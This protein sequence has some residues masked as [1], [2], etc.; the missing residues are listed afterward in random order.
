[1][2]QPPTQEQLEQG[3]RPSA[4]DVVFAKQVILNHL[5]DSPTRNTTVLIRSVLQA[6][7]APLLD[8]REAN[9]APL[10]EQVARCKWLAAARLALADL[11][12]AGLLLPLNSPGSAQRELSIAIKTTHYSHGERF[13]GYDLI[14]A[15]TYRLSG[16]ASNWDLTLLYDPDIYLSSLEAPAMHDRIR[17][18]VIE[19]VDCYRNGLYLAS[20]IM[21]G[22]ASEGAWVELATAV[23]SALEDETPRRLTAELNRPA[24]SMEA[25]QQQTHST[26]ANQCSDALRSID[27]SKSMW[28]GIFETASYYRTLRNYAVHLKEGI[29]RLDYATIGTILARARDYFQDIY[30]LHSAISEPNSG[31]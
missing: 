14:L 18:A 5:T 8:D 27:V 25:I 30:R 29:D 15:T 23:V 22:T 1:M 11:A 4:G 19:A 9:D 31:A 2:T 13:N 6:A 21:L 10:D 3:I 26:I 16:R 28:N 24:P 20:A 12:G 7:E 17:A